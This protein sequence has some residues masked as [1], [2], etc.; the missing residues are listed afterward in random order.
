MFLQDFYIKFPLS[1]LKAKPALQHILITTNLNTTTFSN[2][3]GSSQN[4]ETSMSSHLLERI[5][6]F[7]TLFLQTPKVLSNRFSISDW[8]LKKDMCNG[9]L[10]T[11]GKSNPFFFDFIIHLYPLFPPANRPLSFKNIKDP[12][13]SSLSLSS[14]SSFLSSVIPALPS[15]LEDFR[16]NHFLLTN[17]RTMG[18]RFHFTTSSSSSAQHSFILH[19]LH[20]I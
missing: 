1:R 10:L 7:Q 16:V 13:T 17:L 3:Y 5:F 20:L 19:Y 11:M 12:H 14:F 6:L 9:F 2:L 18:L 15:S 4:A 8:N